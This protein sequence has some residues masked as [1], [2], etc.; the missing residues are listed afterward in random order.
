MIIFNVLPLTTYKRTF[1]KVVG[2]IIFSFY[3]NRNAEGIKRRYGRQALL[4][5]KFTDKVSSASHYS[6]YKLELITYKNIMLTQ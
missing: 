3:I 2:R 6:K 5:Y 4:I 1:L